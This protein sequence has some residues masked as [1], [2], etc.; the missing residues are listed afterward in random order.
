MR[1]PFEGAKFDE[2]TSGDRNPTNEDNFEEKNNFY[3]NAQIQRLYI[4]YFYDIDRVKPKETPNES[5]GAI[6]EQSSTGTTKFTTVA[7][8]LN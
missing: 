4:D 3:R 6:N 7:T 1:S 2:N 5:K 8:H